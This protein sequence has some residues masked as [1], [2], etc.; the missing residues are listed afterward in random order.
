M[1]L[2][3]SETVLDKRFTEPVST[4]L[5]EFIRFNISQLVDSFQVTLSR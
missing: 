4:G 5:D 1:L 3:D 2:V